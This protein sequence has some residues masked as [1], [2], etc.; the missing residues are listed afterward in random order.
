MKH[1]FNCQFIQTKKHKPYNE[2]MFIISPFQFFHTI[3]NYFVFVLFSELNELFN[4]IDK[5]TKRITFI[6]KKSIYNASQWVNTLLDRLLI[7]D[8][9]IP[10]IIISDRNPE[11]ISDIWLFFFSADGH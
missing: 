1:C 6:P 9:G 8:W 10:I 3:I 4:V 7:T 5:F 2:L 11:K